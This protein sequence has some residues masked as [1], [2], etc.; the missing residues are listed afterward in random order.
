MTS[1]TFILPYRRSSL[2]RV[3]RRDLVLAAADSL[4]LRVTI[5]ES[6]D[7]S[8]QTLLIT[9][10]VG[11]PA[12]RFSIW[13]DAP[14]GSY[15]YGA[16]TWSTARRLLYRTAGVVSAAA[17]SFD[18]TLPAGT[19]MAGWPRRLIYAVQLDWDDATSSELLATGALQLMLAPP[20]ASADLVLTTDD[21]VP[22]YADDGLTGI[23]A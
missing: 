12:L 6:D 3:P 2:N 8:A 16:Y 15:D 20:G 14:G 13:A 23:D 9:G 21:G 22:I 4:Q 10:G 17:G 7:P 1:A 5:I 18:V 19:L 11:G